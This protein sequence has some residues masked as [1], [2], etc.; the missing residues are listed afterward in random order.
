MS[1]CLSNQALIRILADLGTPSEHAH[2]AT[3][4][5]CALRH[6]RRRRE[7]DVVRR[8]LM[9]TAEPVTQVLPSPRRWLPA[10]VALLAV[11]MVGALVWTEVVLWNA[12]ESTP[13]QA[14]LEQAAGSL[15]EMSSALFSVNGEPTENLLAP[16]D[17][18]PCGGSLWVGEEAECE[19]RVASVEI[20][21]VAGDMFDSENQDDG[22][23][24]T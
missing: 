7:M 18:G 21:A 8:V 5:G 2:L 23:E 12:I 13:D 9:T 19:D 3:C 15:A 17:D 11:V 14:R 6:A 22:G 24:G 1:P 4:P 16:L 10:A 20:G